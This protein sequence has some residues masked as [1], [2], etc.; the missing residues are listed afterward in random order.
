MNKEI[1]ELAILSMVN[2]I[3]SRFDKRFTVIVYAGRVAN[4]F[5]EGTRSRPAGRLRIQ[6][7]STEKSEDGSF[8]LLHKIS[9]TACCFVI[10]NTIGYKALPSDFLIFNI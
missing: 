1:K 3:C 4:W 10:N 2:F 5:T 8:T 7:R 9:R 6:I